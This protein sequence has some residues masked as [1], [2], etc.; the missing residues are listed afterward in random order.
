MGTCSLRRQFTGSTRS[1]SS[2]VIHPG[3]RGRPGR[4]P[5][6]DGRSAGRS[7]PVP[8]TR[9]NACEGSRSAP[10]SSA[11]RAI[12]WRAVVSRNPWCSGWSGPRRIRRGHQGQRFDD[13]VIV[14]IQATRI[15]QRI[16]QG[17][18]PERYAADGGGGYLRYAGGL[19]TFVADLS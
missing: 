15:V 2:V 8:A 12:S 9:L 16:G 1:A 5:R 7:R 17:V 3:C 10:M 19:Q 11:R 18:T 6:G 4:F 14:D 13:A